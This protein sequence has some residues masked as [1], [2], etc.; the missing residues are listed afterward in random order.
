MPNVR[1]AID[2]GATF[3]KVI[4]HDPLSVV[5]SSTQFETPRS[6][7]DLKKIIEPLVI[8]FEI[9]MLGLS[10]PGLVRNGRIERS[11]NLPA[12]EG[13]DFSHELGID[14]SKLMIMNDLTAHTWGVQ[15]H[16]PHLR[17]YIT[18]CLGTGMGVGHMHNGTVLTDVLGGGEIGHVSA[19]SD[20]VLFDKYR[21][22]MCACGGLGC[23]ERVLCGGIPDGV[24]TVEHKLLQAKVLAHPLATLRAMYGGEFRIVLCGGRSSEWRGYETYLRNELAKTTV[25]AGDPRVS[26]LDDPFNAAYGVLYRLLG[27]KKMGHF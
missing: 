10:V 25:I 14:K 12:W 21:S 6:P 27:P 13:L 16:H 7:R 23:L 26:I 1:V 8:D 15:Y 2:V 17:S 24:S 20:D 5:E 9:R 4:T 22:R 19:M 3:T 18:V 11:V